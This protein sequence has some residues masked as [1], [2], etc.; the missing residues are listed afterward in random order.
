MFLAGDYSLGEEE[1]MKHLILIST[2]VLV[3]SATGHADDFE[4]FNTE[5]LDITQK[6][7]NGILH[8]SSVAN[9]KK[10]SFAWSLCL[11]DQSRFNALEPGTGWRGNNVDRVDAYDT[12]SV[13]ISNGGISKLYSYDSSTTIMSGGRADKVFIYDLT[14]GGPERLLLAGGYILAL[15][16]SIALARDEQLQYSTS[17]SLADFGLKI[18][19]G[20]AYET[21]INVDARNTST[22][23]MAGGKVG[24]VCAYD[25]SKILVS[26]GT[27][28]NLNM[29]GWSRTAVS[30]G[31][32]NTLNA[33]NLRLG[34]LPRVEI[35][36][37]SIGTLKAELAFDNEVEFVHD[38]TLSIADLAPFGVN[39]SGETVGKLN[40][41][42]T[43]HGNSMTT[44]TGGEIYDL[45][46]HESG[47]G[48]ISGGSV[49]SLK[50]HDNSTVL[51]EGGQVTHVQMYN[52]SRLTISDTAN[53]GSSTE[54]TY[55]KASGFSR[56]DIRG[57]NTYR[58]N[59]LENSTV[60]MTGG[61]TQVLNMANTSTFNLFGGEVEMVVHSFDSSVVN[62]HGG[63]TPNLWVHDTGSANVFDGWIDTVQALDASETSIKGGDVDGMA[64]S[65][66]STVRLSGGTVNS[67]STYDDA[68]VFLSGG[69]LNY[70]RV[71]EDSQVTFV[72]GE[73]ILGD[74][75]WLQDEELMGTGILNGTWYDGTM[76]R[77]NILVNEQTGTILLTP[78]PASLLLM[79][80]GGLALRRRKRSMP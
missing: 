70:L 21:Q 39:V 2:V 78:E 23:E 30:G 69:N 41:A 54:D 31:T 7:D 3:L 49:N 58:I 63:S 77:T 8:D 16:P 26:D 46:L 40:T 25:M 80:L 38:A 17:S 14:W 20:T 13:S 37:G 35:S 6:Y 32:I 4:L 51:V 34:G 19:G 59:A 9:A 50:L 75:L 11:Y 57:G 29:D 62:M 52:H 74:G 1:T 28:G 60:E 66:N 22:F 76:W 5:Q 47:S 72:A 27:I 56:I 15:Y 67:M 79:G 61:R 44:V 68:T 36:G 73:F 10:G 43:N 65:R 55:L 33:N 12:S 53:V 42:L 48:D 24:D 45:S 18:Q 71:R 64:A